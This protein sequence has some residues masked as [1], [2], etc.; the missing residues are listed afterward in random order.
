MTVPAGTF[1]TLHIKRY[2]QRY[3]SDYWWAPA[4]R[5]WVKSQNSRNR[6]TALVSYRLN[7][8]APSR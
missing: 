3:T 2:E 1:K 5:M 7:E 6:H 4:V 8:P